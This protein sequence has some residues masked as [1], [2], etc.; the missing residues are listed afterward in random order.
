VRAPKKEDKEERIFLRNQKH[1]LLH[2]RVLHCL[3]F[4]CSSYR[5]YIS[6]C[7]GPSEFA[8]EIVIY[9]IIVIYIFSKSK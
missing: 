2:V 8:I 1:P 3:K 5:N 6:A 7:K 4:C 9:K